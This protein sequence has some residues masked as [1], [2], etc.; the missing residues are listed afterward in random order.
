MP[1]LS[2]LMRQQNYYIERLGRR[3]IERVQK[4]DMVLKQQQARL[5]VEAMHNVKREAQ[6][7]FSRYATQE[8]IDPATAKMVAATAD[9]K[10]LSERAKEY[11]ANRHDKDFAF[12]MDANAEMRLYNL[13]MKVSRAEIALR[14]MDLV[15]MEL[16]DNLIDMTGHHIMDMTESDLYRQAM[17]L[18]ETALTPTQIASVADVLTR[19]PVYDKTFMETHWLNTEKAMHILERGFIKSLLQGKNPRTWSKALEKTLDP[20]TQSIKSKAAQIAITETAARQELLAHAMAEAAGFTHYMI[21]SERDALV[22][23]VCSAID[24]TIVASRDKHMGLNAPPFHPYCRCRT[25]PYVLAREDIDSDLRALEE[26]VAR[27]RAMD[28]LEEMQIEH[29]RYR[30]IDWQEEEGHEYADDMIEYIG[31][32]LRATGR[33]GG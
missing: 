13:S 24:G 6:G 2:R 15:L 33:I 12:S 5:I 25:E 30:P 22:C 16:A 10:Y 8:G 32:F 28:Q 3:Q 19:E 14:S 9:I 4:Q 18:G 17:V 11:V 31:K 29:Y 23:E 20:L 27:L 7:W 26:H 1:K 21:I